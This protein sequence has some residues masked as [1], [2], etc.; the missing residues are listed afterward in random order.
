MGKEKRSA[1]A[2]EGQRDLLAA[3]KQAEIESQKKEKHKSIIIGICIALVVVLMIGVMA[4]NKI[5]DSGYF[6]RREVAAESENYKV[7]AAMM[8]YFFNTNYQQ[9]ASMAS[10]IGIDTSKSLKAQTNPMGNG[11]WF[12]YFMS[13][14]RAYVNEVLALCE[15]A[16]AN[17]ISLDEKDQA[18]IDGSISALK[19]T[20]KSRGYTVNQYLVTSF[21]V[22]IKEK[23]VR[24]CLE[25]T[26]LASKYANIY[27]ESLS[28]GISDCESYYSENPDSFNGVD[29]L[30]YSISRAD[31]METDE[32]G[33]V[34]GDSE[35][36]QASA[37]ENA[38]KLAAASS[39]DEFKSLIKSYIVDVLG[40]E[41]EHAAEHAED[42]LIVHALKTNSSI[43][44]VADWAFSASAGE[45]TVKASDD[46][47]VFDVY[48]LSATPYR[49]ETPTRN[50]RHILFAKD[51]Y[52]D[53]DACKAAAESAYAEWESAG[54]SDDKFNSLCEQ[55]SDDGGSNTNNGLYENVKKGDMVAEFD[56][57]LYD[58]GRAS[59][60][61]GMVQT[62]YGW[63]IMNYSGESD[64]KAWQK[65]AESALKTQAYKDMVEANSASNTFYTNVLNG[66]S[67]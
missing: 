24:H 42:A 58:S 36:A 61:H 14:T 27:N 4:Y 43:S 46:E 32:D 59:G 28:Y 57:W 8:T 16:K 15:A 66:I 67:A 65:D 44:G 1:A 49:D 48:Y 7:D 17:N 2:V 41:E 54:F 3:K 37:K 50:V 64:V 63:H 13:N 19:A 52:D 40:E 38:D 60:D 30:K 18:D 29:I 10:Y 56:E 21:G 9:Y 5:S 25:L 33:N 23:D 62:S 31:F 35:A 55:Y 34:T 20:A 11:T 6:L 39:A 22:N 45:T 51:S 47:T 26:V 12:D 53:E